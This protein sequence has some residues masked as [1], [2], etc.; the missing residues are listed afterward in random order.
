M[1]SFT[2][3]YTT[4]PMRAGEQDGNEYFFVN[5]EKLEQLKEKAAETPAP[6]PSKKDER[7]LV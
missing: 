3:G 4:R 2:I 1:V 6:I 5:N 7:E